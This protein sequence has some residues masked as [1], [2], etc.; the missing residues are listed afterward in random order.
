MT[1][2]ELMHMI[3]KGQLLLQGCIKLSFDD[4]FYAL[5]GQIHLV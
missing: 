4:Q 1:G 3:C 5:A 2:I